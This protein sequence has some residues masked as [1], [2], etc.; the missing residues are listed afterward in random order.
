MLCNL[1][2]LIRD[3]D[4]GSVIADIHLL[5][6][7]TVRNTV[8]AFF[9]HDMIIN[10]HFG[11]FPMAHDVTFLRKWSQASLLKLNKALP[12]AFAIQL[13][14]P[15]IEFFKRFGNADIEFLKAEELTVS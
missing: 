4:K 11:F 9:K 5:A 14:R 13:H 7:Q 8:E 1:G 12:A 2:S 3:G 15:V 6:D 10:M